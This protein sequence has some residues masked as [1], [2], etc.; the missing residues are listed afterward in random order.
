[1]FIAPKPHAELHP[2]FLVG[3]PARLCHSPVRLSGLSSSSPYRTEGSKHL[4]GDDAPARLTD[5]SFLKVGREAVEKPRWDHHRR[6]SG[7][8]E[9]PADGHCPRSATAAPPGLAASDGAQRVTGCNPGRHQC[10]VRPKP[11]QKH[12]AFLPR[13]AEFADQVD[14]RPVIPCAP[15]RRGLWRTRR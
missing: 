12:C 3:E 14:E 9:R 5:R 4:N 11:R 8:R 7:P 15:D 2:A 13:F 10:A 1:M 6:P